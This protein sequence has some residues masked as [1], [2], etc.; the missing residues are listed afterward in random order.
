MERSMRRLVLALTATAGLAASPAGAHEPRQT[1]GVPDRHGVNP[2]RC[3]VPYPSVYYGGYIGVPAYGAFSDRGGPTPS[4]AGSLGYLHAPA[5]Y[6]PGPGGRRIGP[7]RYALHG[8][9]GVLLP[10]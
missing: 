9:S 4:Y 8:Y 7:L 3:P 1:Y 10:W 2:T 6:R 5:W